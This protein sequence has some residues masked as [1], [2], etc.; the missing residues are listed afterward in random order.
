M[1]HKWIHSVQEWEMRGKR[2][3]W[4]PSQTF[5]TVLTIPAYFT[6]CAKKPSWWIGIQIDTFGNEPIKITLSLPFESSFLRDDRPGITLESKPTRSPLLDSAVR[7][8][9]FELL[10]VLGIP[11][12]AL[13]FT[14]SF[15]NWTPQGQLAIFLKQFSWKTD[16]QDLHFST[17]PSCSL[18][19]LHKLEASI[20]FSDLSL[21][22]V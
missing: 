7:F 21:S 12:S 16:L 17:S 15:L 2:K 1:Y 4:V 13:C 20:I 18:K 19:K 8:S 11:S 9:K 3:R 22:N 6:E 10:F 14:S 5:R